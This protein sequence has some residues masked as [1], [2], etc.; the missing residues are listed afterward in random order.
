MNY[1]KLF[2]ISSS[3]KSFIG[4]EIYKNDQ[5]I[6]KECNNFIN[7]DELISKKLKYKT[8]IN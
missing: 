4:D 1:I 7:F 2:R 3:V 6:V 5:K 8:M